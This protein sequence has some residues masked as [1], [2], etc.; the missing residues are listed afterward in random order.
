MAENKTKTNSFPKDKA[1]AEKF[2]LQMVK[3]I[4]TD[5]KIK[6]ILQEQSQG[7]APMNAVLGGIAS[8]ILI[9]LFTKL[10]EQTGGMQ[11][12]PKWVV[13]II[14]V[15]VKELSILADSMGMDTPVED[16]QIAAQIA[17]DSLDQSMQEL[18]SNR[19]QRSGQPQQ[20]MMAQQGQPQPQPQQGMPQPQPQQGMI[21]QA[22]PQGGM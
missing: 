22:Q 6:Q 15:A 19:G 9:L 20:G 1:Q 4:H 11:V 14:R 7:G 12:K 17:G 8:Q 5:E 3:L 10:M 2:T 21:A 16:E 18:Y 13:E